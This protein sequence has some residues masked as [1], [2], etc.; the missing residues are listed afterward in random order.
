M[1]IYNLFGFYVIATIMI[2]FHLYLKSRIFDAKIQILE[3]THEI[4]RINYEIQIEE[5]EEVLSKCKI[6]F[7]FYAD[8][9]R[10]KNTD[11]ANKKMIANQDMSQMIVDVLEKHRANTSIE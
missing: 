9:H 6:T 11:D 10:A 5:L 3:V 8:N 1:T 2:F 4:S 7:D